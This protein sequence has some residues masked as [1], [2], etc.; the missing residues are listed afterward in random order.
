M[1]VADFI[2]GFLAE[3]GVRRIYGFPGSPLVP[4]LAA[5]ARQDRIRWIL[6]RHENAAA[7]AAAADSKL[8]G[9]LGVALVTSGPGVLQAVCGVAD[10]HL[11]RAPLLLLSGLVSRANQGHWDF[12]DV[13]QVALYRALLPASVAAV[14]AG[15]TA[16][17]LRAQVSMAE[18]RGVATRLALPLDLLDEALPEGDDRFGSRGFARGVPRVGGLPALAAATAALAAAQRPVI[19]VG[20][21]AHGAGSDI[22]RLAEQLDAPIVAALD[23]KGVVDESARH[24]L[25]V[26]GIFGFP[27][28]GATARVVAEADLVVAFGVENLKPFLTDGQHVQRRAVLQVQTEPAFFADEY[29]SAESLSGP[30]PAIAAALAAAVPARPPGMVL[31]QLAAERLATMEEVLGR[32]EVAEAAGTGLANPLDFLLQLNTRLDA[33]H[34]LAVDTGSHTIWAALFLRLKHGQ[35]M[36]VSGRL[37]TMGFCL[38]ALIAAQ[39][40]EPGKRAIGIA[41]DGGF[42]MTGAE[43]ATAVA[44]RLPIVLVV[45]NNGTLQNVAAQQAEPFGTDLLNPDFVALAR[46]YGADGAVVDGGTD[47]DAVL[48]AALAPRTT[49]FVIDLRCDPALLA[50]LSKWEAAGYAAYSPA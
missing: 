7:L 50:P 33:R 39:L 30:L 37:G 1:K 46:A 23:G 31:P 27:G 45:V 26:L 38:P 25:G 40:A 18:A 32:L 13:D 22:L 19:V 5:L 36:L 43:L 28:I 6:M 24:Y 44:N 3:A 49:P 42:A 15:Q 12:Q 29:G 41:G 10:A 34:V 16:A 2:L 11:D 20:R 4:L 9:K 47:V 14:S 35:R 48:D 17:L 21:R 8:T